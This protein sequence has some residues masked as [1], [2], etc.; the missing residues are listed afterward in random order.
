M[1][2]MIDAF[3]EFGG[4]NVL[5]KAREMADSIGDRVRAIV[6]SS[7]SSD[8]QRLLYLG[9]D[10]VLKCDTK[11]TSDWIDLFSSLISNE[12]QLKLVIFPSN[13]VCNAIMG[14]IYAKESRKIS[15]Y[16][17]DADL[18]DSS[19]VTKSLVGTGFAFQSSLDGK[20]KL[21][22]IKTSS[23]SPPFE[24]SSRYGKVRIAEWKKD[25]GFKSVPL[26]VESGIETSKLTILV[27]PD[28]SSV[29]YDLSEKLGKKYMARVM[30]LSR[31]IEV[32]YGPCLAVGI[33]ARARDLPRFEGYLVAINSKRAPITAI[34]DAVVQ[35]Q[36]IET[37]LSTM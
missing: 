19:N 25:D 24:D 33:E 22:S 10:E 12:A 1:K 20:V 34:A 32:I 5:G 29:V 7:R 30:K 2:C 27:G 3:C 35:S 15:L 23:L 8:P 26:N 36:D 37:I 28:T 31:E 18:L 16:Y 14:A 4:E 21:V 9:A 13:V 17:D 11:E 6:S